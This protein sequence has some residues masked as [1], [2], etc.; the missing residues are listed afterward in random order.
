MLPEVL[1]KVSCFLIT[2][3][4]LLF[5]H[6]WNNPNFP[7]AKSHILFQCNIIF[8]TLTSSLQK[9]GSSLLFIPTSSATR[10]TILNNALHFFKCTKIM[11]LSKYIY[12]KLYK[13][14][15]CNKYCA[16]HRWKWEPL[17]KFY[18]NIFHLFSSRMTVV[19]LNG[20]HPG[21]SS[22]G[23]NSPSERCNNKKSIIDVKHD[24]S[25]FPLCFVRAS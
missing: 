22:S 18:F 5:I 11:K 3:W 2:Y 6:Q 17:H 8:H 20:H 4:Y 7:P 9:G 23:W 12:I 14:V 24:I 10:L 21:F 19:L 25:H 1:H 13:K 16:C 15:E